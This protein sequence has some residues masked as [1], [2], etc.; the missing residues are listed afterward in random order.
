MD[1]TL[2]V[3]GEDLANLGKLTQEPPPLQGPF[4]VSGNVVDPELKVYRISD[5]DALL[6]D[7]D[8]NGWIE[9]NLTGERPRITAELSSG[10]VD[11]RPFLVKE[12]EITP[13]EAKKKERRVF[14]DE[15]LPL[16]MLGLVDGS[17]KI[18]ARQ[19]LLPRLALDDLVI[20]AVL[21]D[22]NLSVDPFQSVIGG[23]LT[24][25]RL[26]LHTRDKEVEMATLFEIDQLDIG[27]M[28]EELGVE[29]FIEAT[30]DAKMEVEGQGESVAGLMA[31]LN[32]TF[33]YVMSEGQLNNRFV[34]RF[35]G[36]IINQILGLMNPFSKKEQY[37]E[38][39]CA[40]N[41]FVIQD[42]LAQCKGWVVDT[43]HTTAIA[44]GDIDLRTEELNLLFGLSPKKG[45]GLRGLFK[46]G[47][48]LGKLSKSFKLGG[49]LAE[50]S[51]V[52]N[53]RGASKM[54]GTAAGG[55]LLLG[56]FGLAA[57]LIDVKV[58]QEHPC[59]DVMED[60]EEKAGTSK[61]E[62]PQEQKGKKRKSPE[63][64]GR[65]Y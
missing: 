5:F 20:D 44:T 29:K 8:L 47:F 16:E 46:V 31:G 1:L 4:S 55:M 40:V 12:K 30:L 35:G 42:G 10:N 19:I 52:L 15:P 65:S 60:I 39:N 24:K 62:G 61:S 38:V 9:L 64:I 18:R 48:S 22:G 17:F 50:P 63:G 2:T 41:H 51:I 54:L 59:L 53:P 56:P 25:A 11:L 28:L 45:V 6:G 13:V 3:R 23:G 36:N 26:T 57:P 37:S 32:G 49:T 43:K 34:D 58:G 14:P 27:V 33:V 21:E 7:N